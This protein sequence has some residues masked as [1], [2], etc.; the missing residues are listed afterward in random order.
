ML[1][2]RKDQP[3]T[4]SSRN[5]G[6]QFGHVGITRQTAQV[7]DEEKKIFLRVCPDCGLPLKHSPHF[8]TH[9][10]ED[11]PELLTN[12]VTVTNYHINE[13]YCPHCQKHVRALPQNVIPGSRLG[14]NL[15]LFSLVLRTVSNQSLYQ[16]SKVIKLL[17]GLEISPG[18]IQAILHR[19]REY[20]GE[21]YNDILKA[22][23]KAK[24]K[25]A[26]ET[27]WKTNGSTGWDWVFLTTNEVYHTIRNTRG[28]GW[29]QLSSRLHFND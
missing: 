1:F 24:V 20:L 18:G 10:V 7:F 9:L 27:S 28:K 2:G 22:I 4:P 17:F 5:R 29:S 19:A 11:I 8:K 13:Q 23:Q 16:I 25:H 12:Q 3:R 6:G 26:D 15:V 14:L 21:S